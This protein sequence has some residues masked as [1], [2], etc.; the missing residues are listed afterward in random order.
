MVNESELG[1]N[2]NQHVGIPVADKKHSGIMQKHIGQMFKPKIAPKVQVR[3]KPARKGR[4][5]LHTPS[6][7]S[8]NRVPVTKL[9]LR[10][11]Y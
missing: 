9:E 4:G 1:W 8:S 5:Q 7:V 2:F 10:K 11:F 6:V 3:T